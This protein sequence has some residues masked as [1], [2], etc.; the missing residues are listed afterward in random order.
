M[1][2]KSSKTDH[3]LSI[4]M[5]AEEPKQESTPQETAKVEPVIRNAVE[6]QNKQLEDEV[7]ETV[8]QVLTE[9]LEEGEENKFIEQQEQESIEEQGKE[10]IEEGS[11]AAGNVEI[12]ETVEE[13]SYGLRNIVEILIEDYYLEF[14]TEENMC[15]CER[16]QWDVKAVAL[17]HILPQYCVVNRGENPPL[18]N[19]FRKKLVNTIIVETINACKIVKNMPNHKE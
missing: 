11:L 3:V 12:Q 5:S 1:A 4:L 9:Q 15:M 18:I 8:L 14:M 17:S 10:S 13:K 19:Y 6:L 2:K 7:N 16:C